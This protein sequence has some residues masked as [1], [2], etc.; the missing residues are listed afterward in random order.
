MS[1]ATRGPNWRPFIRK[2]PSCLKPEPPGLHPKF[3]IQIQSGNRSSAGPSQA[4]QSSLV[5]G[6]AE[7]LR[8][9]LAA[10]IKKRRLGTGLRIDAHRLICFGQIAGRARQGAVPEF[11]RAPLRRRDNMF[12]MVAIA[13]NTLGREA[14][15]ASCPCTLLHQSTQPGRRRFSPSFGQVQSLS[16]L[17]TH[18][19][20][21]PAC[22][23]SQASIPRPLEREI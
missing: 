21:W 6:P 9:M 16:E 7:V 17:S 11:V 8:P 18:G 3:V 10:W 12:E 19:A 2:E 20:D 14:V 22:A 1:S 13:A 4:D 5:V 15:L 23:R